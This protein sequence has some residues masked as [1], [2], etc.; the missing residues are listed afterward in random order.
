VVQIRDDKEWSDC[1]TR[2]GENTQ[3]KQ[4]EWRTLSV[5]IFVGLLRSSSALIYLCHCDC[6]F[7]SDMLKLAEPAMPMRQSAGA[8]LAG[9]D[10]SSAAG[11]AAGGAGRRIYDDDDALGLDALLEEQER[12]VKQERDAAAYGQWGAKEEGEGEGEGERRSQAL[13]L[14]SSPPPQLPLFGLDAHMQGDGAGGV[15]VGALYAEGDGAL[16]WRQGDGAAEGEGMS[17]A[18]SALDASPAGKKKGKKRKAND[19]S[20]KVVIK[21]GVSSFPRSWGEPLVPWPR[22]LRLA[23]TRPFFL[24]H[25]ALVCQ[26][27]IDMAIF[28][29]SRFPP[30]FVRRTCPTSFW[31]RPSS[32]TSVSAS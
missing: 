21:K 14:A 13:D 1:M 23:L 4:E 19:A 31:H 8:L 2:D 7:A 12:D 25:V 26:S 3:R 22:L 28:P 17:G 5:G 18:A 24:F 15:E 10:A 32:R 30:S 16:D 11:A 27:A 29:R 6:A 20:K 9:D